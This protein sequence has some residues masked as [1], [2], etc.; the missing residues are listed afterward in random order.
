MDRIDDA[1]W[2]KST[3]SGGAN[4]DCV[5]AGVAGRGHGRVLVRDTADR[6]GGM[7]AFPA[8]AWAAFT[9]SLKH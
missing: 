7:L 3:Y 5:E 4:S 9:S 8:A 2:R 1:T 6:D